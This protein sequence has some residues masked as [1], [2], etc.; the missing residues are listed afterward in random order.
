MVDIE[1][2]R[3]VMELL[4]DQGFVNADDDEELD[5]VTELAFNAFND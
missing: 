3:E 1:K 5:T 4:R 2:V